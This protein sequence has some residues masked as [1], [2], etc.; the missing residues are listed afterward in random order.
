M[1][2]SYVPS[3]RTI[4][5]VWSIPISLPIAPLSLPDTTTTKL[6]FL[7]TVLSSIVVGTCTSSPSKLTKQVSPSTCEIT[8]VE[9]AN[10][11]PAKS[12]SVI[13]TS[14]FGKTHEALLGAAG[15]IVYAPGV[16]GG[17]MPG[18]P[19]V[20]GTPGVPGV[21]GIIIPGVPGVL[22][23]P[24]G[25]VGTILCMPGVLGIP[26]VCG[27]PKGVGGAPGVLGGIIPGVPGVRGG[28]ETMPGVPGV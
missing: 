28:R 4:A 16:L 27:A 24:I 2:R 14:I 7:G 20:A 23:M 18:V 21:C 8:P 12:L 19:G 26:G 15:S 3:K 6:L 17:I 5:S 25:V 22:G 10:F 11:P 9:F 1:R 13:L